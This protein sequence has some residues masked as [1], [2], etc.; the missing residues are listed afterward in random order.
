MD[1][2]IPSR[3][4]GCGVGDKARAR[5]CRWTQLATAAIRSHLTRLGF[6]EEQNNGS[7]VAVPLEEGRLSALRLCLIGP[8]ERMPTVAARAMVGHLQRAR[9]HFTSGL[10]QDRER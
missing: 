7:L 2:G 3:T 6:A 4:Y 10:D 8:S 5:R 9:A 1:V